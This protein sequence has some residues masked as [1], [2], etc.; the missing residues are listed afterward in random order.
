MA[1]GAHV[2]GWRV[3]DVSNDVIFVTKMK[4]LNYLPIAI[5]SD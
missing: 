3:I 4:A 1:E 2:L 5:D